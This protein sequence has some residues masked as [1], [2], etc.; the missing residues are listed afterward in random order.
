MAGRSGSLRR[1]SPLYIHQQY[2]HRIATR[3]HFVFHATDFA[4]RSV[5]CPVHQPGN[6]Q[7][8]LRR[9]TVLDFGVLQEVDVTVQYVFGQRAGRRDIQ[10]LFIH[11]ADL[12]EVRLRRFIVILLPLLEPAQKL[13]R[14][15]L[16]FG[17]ASL[18]HGQKLGH[19]IVTRAL[20]AIECL[21]FLRAEAQGLVVRHFQAARCAESP[22]ADSGGRLAETF[23][24]ILVPMVGE[25][26][27]APIT[28]DEMKPV[29]VGEA[30]KVYEFW[31][32]PAARK[33]MADQA[34]ST[35]SAGAGRLMSAVRS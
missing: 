24:Q 12:V 34:A 17:R 23:N 8:P 4:R 27:V 10:Q 6:L 33:V 16:P 1:Q 29:S 35:S 22:K 30:A 13:L 2:H 26:A 20:R 11:E 31:S 7:V 28:P 32:K 21:L 18:F 19:V 9:A 25:G 3:A 14:R 5:G 15:G